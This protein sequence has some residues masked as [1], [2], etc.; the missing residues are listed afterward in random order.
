MLFA[1]LVTYPLAKES[2]FYG[3]GMSDGST[4][5]PH[6]LLFNLWDQELCL[7]GREDEAEVR[8]LSK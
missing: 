5:T 7:S 6:T 3:H 8:R 2:I 1:S 4:S